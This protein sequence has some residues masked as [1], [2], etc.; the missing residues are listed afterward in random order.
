LPVVLVNLWHRLAHRFLGWE[1]VTVF[2][3]SAPCVCRVDLDAG[4]W[5][6]R[7]GSARTRTAALNA[8]GTLST[9]MRWLATHWRPLTPGVA[10]FYRPNQ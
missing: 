10:E 9:N 5:R 7:L 1:Y 2:V 8:D 6:P 3:Y 4:V